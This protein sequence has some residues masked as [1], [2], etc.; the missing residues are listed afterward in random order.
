MHLRKGIRHHP[1][2]LK[3]ILKTMEEKQIPGAEIFC[4]LLPFMLHIKPSDRLA[5]K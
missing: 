3:P 4:L 5:I 1:G 2:S